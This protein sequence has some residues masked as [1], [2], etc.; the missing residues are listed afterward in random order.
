MNCTQQCP[1]SGQNTE[2][3]NSCKTKCGVATEKFNIKD[4]SCY[5]ALLSTWRTAIH[6]TGP[7][8]KMQQACLQTSY[9][10]IFHFTFP[11]PSMQ[12]GGIKGNS[13]Q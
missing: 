9:L 4:T 12:H 7:V 10:D 11:H 6:Q 8:Y 1:Q 5:A 3:G 2:L 13:I